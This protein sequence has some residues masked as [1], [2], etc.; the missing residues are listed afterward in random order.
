MKKCLINVYFGKAP[1]NITIWA[2]SA[3]FNTDIDFL[4][5]TNSN[6]FNVIKNLYSN[7]IVRPMTTS[8]FLEKCSKC[9]GFV[10][11]LDSAYKLCDYKVA[12][13]D[14]FKN[15]I[16]KYSFWGFFDFD[17]VFGNI[18]K[19]LPDEIFEKY[20]NISIWGH[21]SF[22]R[23][24]NKMRELY[25]QQALNASVNYPDVFKNSYI[26]ITDEY[27]RKLLLIQNNIT[28]FD[29]TDLI[30]DMSVLHK[31]FRNV[32]N[33]KISDGFICSFYDGTLLCHYKKDKQICTEEILYIHLQKRK[34]KNDVVSLDK[35]IIIKPNQYINTNNFLIFNND[36]YRKNGG[37]VKFKPFY[38]VKQKLADYKRRIKNRILKSKINNSVF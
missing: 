32:F 18:N 5:Y 19:F 10:P 28:S 25:K 27:I 4:I 24:N 23:N 16:Q 7:I 38:F 6:S 1:N 20:E 34:M 31:S 30:C 36:F 22:L 11:S 35:P 29:T 12:Y 15:D 33:K 3:S 21:L 17:V 37:G 8:L 9:F 13:G 26:W 2:K 14:I